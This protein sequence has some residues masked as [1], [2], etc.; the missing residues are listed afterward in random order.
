MDVMT[1]PTPEKEATLPLRG[2]SC[3]MCAA[4]AHKTLMSVPGVYMADVN[5]AME[6]VRL[7]YD[8][9]QTNLS[10]LKALLSEQG[11][12]LIVQ[13]D[14]A[15]Q[16]EA[17]DQAR[18]AE[19]QR[20]GRQM[21]VATLCALPVVAL[22]MYYMHAHGAHYHSPDLWVHHVSALLSAVVL[23]YSARDFYRKAYA[24]LK[25][26]SLG[27][28]ALVALST[29]IAY[30]YSLVVV[31][32]PDLFSSLAHPPM[33]YFE[34]SAMIIL[35]VLLGKWLE[36]RAKWRTSGALR[37]LVA[38]QPATALRLGEDGQAQEVPIGDIRPG[39]RILVR[40]GERI[41]VDGVLRRGTSHV[42]ESLLTGEP[43]PV[44]KQEGDR[45]WS[46]TLNGEGALEVEAK[47]L[48]G[49]TLLASIVRQVQ[50]AQGS[51]APVQRLVDRLSA[52]FVPTVLL[53]SVLTL[54][55]W[56]LLSSAPTAWTDGVVYMVSVLV[57]ACPCALGLATPTALVVGIGRAAQMG[58][59][60]KDAE[61][62]EQ[63]AGVD[64][65]LL[66]KTGTITCG[67]PEVLALHRSPDLRQGDLALLLSLE[68]GSQ[69]PLSSAIVRYLQGL[70]HSPREAVEVQEHAGRGVSTMV[71]GVAYRAGS[72]RWMQ[73]LNVQIGAELEAL[74]QSD[75]QQGASVV[76]YA[77]GESCVAIL[78]L[79]DA[80][81]PTSAVAVRYL[82]RQGIELWMLTGDHAT[83]AQQVATEVGIEH[84]RHS[85]LPADKA[86][87]VRQLRA[88]GRRGIAMVGDGIND[89][90]AL[91]QADLSI[92]M[93]TASD[94]AV[95]TAGVT[96]V[97]A[98]LMRLAD[99][100]ALSRATK[101][102]IRRNLF[103]AF[104]YNL[105][106]LP[107]ATGLL[108]PLWGIA[109]TPMFA[110]LAMTMSSVSVV[111]SSLYLSRTRLR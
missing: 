21:L 104:V 53:I 10:E 36:E 19:Y 15:L 47:G 105:L 97:S 35:F 79:K 82:Q 12:Q 4:H 65:I 6:Q 18:R 84:V 40:P 93:G 100:L 56:G 49:E 30:L 45:L 63:A 59:L 81:R 64:T 92:S 41:A 78:A 46:G 9:A 74:V 7:Q 62:L 80:V 26:L 11:F 60:I 96:I 89:S 20:K 37:A 55:G 102:T 73:E 39:E 106:A 28:D 1:N 69:H 88:Q 101:R 109:I 91:A 85:A 27:M 34:A 8:G 31:Y 98:D 111:L 77:V 86:E 76:Y 68:Q 23:L 2:M 66:D 3:A 50:Q 57:I 16:A 17:E 48:G 108:Y 44:L 103:W 99:L 75:L 29:S 13:E 61:A 110:S 32:V 43:M 33:P 95:Q 72:A 67:S 52:Y 70:G 71:D 94:V 87:L 22:N 83:T 90:I 51:K 54:L 25:A 42:E 38:L 5:L 107:L 14:V 24:S 58:L